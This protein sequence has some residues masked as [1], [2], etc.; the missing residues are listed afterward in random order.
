MKRVGIVGL[1]L[2][3][4]SLAK[5]YKRTQGITVLGSDLDRSIVEFAKLAE[6]IDGELTDVEL[7]NCDCILLAIFPQGVINWVYDKAKK[8]LLKGTTVID[9]AGT[10]GRVCAELFPMAKEHGFTFVGG[11]PMAGLHR[12]GFKFSREDL[13]DGEPMV[14]VPPTNDDIR[15]LDDISTLL[16]PLGFGRISVATAAEHDEIIAF[17]SQMPH[18]ISNAFV[19]S[20]TAPRH[21]GYSAGSYRDLSRVARLDPD[22]WTEL[23]LENKEFLLDEFNYFIQAAEK[24][25]DALKDN[26]PK[27]LRELLDEGSRIKREVDGP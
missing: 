25:R 3:G 18:I 2:I 12:S 6:A 8:G 20:P 14:I 1:G 23:F 26:D 13:F 27:K 16:K 17:A 10:K 22:M 7:I 15:L 21:K 19:K 9:C 5:A 24:Y 4:G 11:H